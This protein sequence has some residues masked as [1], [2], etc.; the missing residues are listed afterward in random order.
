MGAS[1][2][3]RLSQEGARV[4]FGDVADDLG[5]ALER[6]LVGE[7]LDVTYVHLD[8]RSSDDWR[9]AVESAES[10]YGA[11][12]IL[13]NNAGLLGRQ[14]G[15]MACDD[16]EDIVA[17]NQT[18]PFLGMRAAVP[19]FLRA[20]AGSIVN[21]ASVAAHVPAG[22]VAYCASKAAL[23]MMTMSVAHELGPS[24]IRANV[25]SPGLIKTPMTT[26]ANDAPPADA[27]LRRIP[28]RRRG[29]PVDV[30]EA[31]VFLCSPEASYISG[32]EIAVDGGRA[33]QLLW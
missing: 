12:T 23:C 33:K 27:L 11:L 20:G 32:A 30:S 16:F 10:R 4:F 25:V 3:L 19:A 6:R 2:V 8:V 7:G 29:E 13:V 28:L 31:V 15:L 24:G 22:S 21:I 1:H 5:T 18:G 17:V 14:G 9:H 26:G